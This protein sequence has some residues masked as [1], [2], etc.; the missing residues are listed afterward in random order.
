MLRVNRIVI[1]PHSTLDFATGGYHLMLLRPTHSVSPGDRL[2]LTLHYAGGRSQ[3]VDFEVRKPNGSESVP[4]ASH[5]M[6]GM[7]GMKDM[8]DM[9]DMKGMPDMPH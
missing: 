2:H 8:K 1:P 5:A 3:S 4:D 9:K 6:K 7:D